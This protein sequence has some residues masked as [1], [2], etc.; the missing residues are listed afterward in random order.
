MPALIPAALSAASVLGGAALFGAGITWAVVGKA[1]LAAALSLAGS[2]LMPKPKKPGF[3]APT[4]SGGLQT[5]VRQPILSHSYVF[6]RVRTGGGLTFMHSMTGGGVTNG[7]LYL[8]L[9]MAAHRID[10]FETDY[11]DVTQLVV[12]NQGLV[13]SAPYSGFARIEK[14]LG[15]ASQSAFEQFRQEVPDKWTADHRH[16]GCAGVSLRLLYSASVYNQGI[17]Q[18]WAVIR[19]KRL[20]D[21]RDPSLEI[22]SIQWHGNFDGVPCVRIRFTTSFDLVIGDELYIQGNPILDRTVEVLDVSQNS[23]LAMVDVDRVRPFAGQVPGGRATKKRWSRNAALATREYL[24]EPWGC[25]VS[26]IDIDDEYTIFSANVCDEPVQTKKEGIVPRYTCDGVIDVLDKAKR[27]FL[28][29]I[30]SSMAGVITR[31]GSKFRIHAGV[32]VPPVTTIV[33][34]DVREGTVK[35]VSQVT[36]RSAPNIIRS[37]YKG[38]LSKWQVT[39]V[40]RYTSQD[41]VSVDGG[42][43]I[44]EDLELPFTTVNA[45]AQRLTKIA[46]MNQRSQRRVEMPLKLRMMAY[47]AYDRVWIDLPR[48]GLPGSVFRIEK[49]S[50]ADRGLPVLAFKEDR[51][52][53][54]TWD[55]SEEQ[56]FSIPQ[57][58]ELP[59]NQFRSTRSAVFSNSAAVEIVQVPAHTVVASIADFETGNKVVTVTCSFT[60]EMTSTGPTGTTVEAA[61]FRGTEQMRPYETVA[62]AAP[63]QNRLATVSFSVPTPATPGAVSYELRVRK[64]GPDHFTNATNRA[65]IA[66]EVV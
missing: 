17:P 19:G 4:F 57:D 44:Y 64:S 33:E 14:A 37:K 55:V 32:Y 16:R 3:S 10:G 42:I 7:Y 59:N 21:P 50:L 5:N 66:E 11:F 56:D 39:D 34:D 27:D 24:A 22:A 18:Y 25:N 51:P 49:W 46:L 26:D 23:V 61:L 28:E 8:N 58:L 60:I 45:T 53:N 65:M 2:L 40:P 9:T 31:A 35:A 30:L 38:P 1:V 54:W 48:T 12:D 20:F 62:T 47:T 29:E 15:S 63:G 6:G 36:R 41:F 13:Q 52:E 43:P